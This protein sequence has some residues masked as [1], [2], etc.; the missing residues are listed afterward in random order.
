MHLFLVKLDLVDVL[1]LTFMAGYLLCLRSWADI[2]CWTLC[3]HVYSCCAEPELIESLGL[4]FTAGLPGIGEPVSMVLC[5]NGDDVAVSVDNLREYVQA[6]V[7]C[8]LSTSVEKQ[9]GARQPSLTDSMY[10]IWML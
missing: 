10:K 3:D 9:V 4:T 6:Y 8:I 1:C 2:H 5:E 7:D